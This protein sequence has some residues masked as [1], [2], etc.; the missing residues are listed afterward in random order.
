MPPNKKKTRKKLYK[1]MNKSIDAQIV[2]HLFVLCK[3]II[4]FN[5][6]KKMR[7]RRESKL[8]LK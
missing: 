6:Q 1:K 7:A 5:T 8:T 2:F 3:K 4:I